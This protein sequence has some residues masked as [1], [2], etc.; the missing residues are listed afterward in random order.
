MNEALENVLRNDEAQANARYI[1]AVNPVA[2]SEL[3][4]TLESLQRE[5]EELKRDLSHEASHRQKLQ[6]ALAYWMPGVT[7]EIEISTNGRC[8]DDALLLV[9]SEGEF[10]DKCWGNEVLARAEAAEAE[11][12]RLQAEIDRKSSMPGDHRYWEGR[13]R[14]EADENE[15]LRQALKPFAKFEISELKQRAFL[16]ILVCPEGDDHADNY[17]P[18][19]IRARTALASTGGEH[20]GN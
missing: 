6:N 14:D 11:V 2:V 12:A 3:L 20:H 17:G 15:K 18:H 10:E 19:F 5:N 1:A 7:E 13:Y 8:G 9:G 4:S 16:Q